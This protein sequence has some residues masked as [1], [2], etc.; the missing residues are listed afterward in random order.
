MRRV[1]W[2]RVPP[3]VG[4]NAMVAYVVVDATGM[5]LALPA[6]LLVAILLGVTFPLVS[7]DGE[8]DER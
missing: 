8:D 1:H 4:I 3:M 2:L 5:A 7:V 6:V